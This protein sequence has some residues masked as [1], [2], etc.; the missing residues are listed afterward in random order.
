MAQ[1]KSTSI[2]QSMQRLLLLGLFICTTFIVAVPQSM[3]S[4]AAGETSATSMTPSEN[5]V[6]FNVKDPG[7]IYVTETVLEKVVVHSQ[8]KP[9]ITDALLT[10]LYTIVAL[11]F[12][13]TV[14][15]YW[16]TFNRLFGTQRHPY[17]DV[18]TANWPTVTVV[19][20]AHNEEKVISHTIEALLESDYPANK[21]RIMPINDRST[22]DTEAI[23]KDYA[24]KYP[25]KIRPVFRS[26]GKPGKAA[27]LKDATRFIETEILI[28]FDADYIPGK[29]LLKQ[30]VSPFFDPEVGAMMGRVVPHNVGHNLLTRLMDLERSGGYQVDQQARMNMHLVPQY[31]GT[32][33]GV[34]VSALDSVGGWDAKTLAED[35]DLT[36]RLLLAGWKTV[37]QN[38]SE[39]YEEAPETWDARLKQISRWAKGHNLSTARYTLPLLFNR[40]ASLFEKIDGILL[41][42]VYVMSPLLLLGWITAIIL[43]FLG[44]YLM[45]GVISLL[46]LTSFGALGNFA[47]FFEISAAVR[48]DSCR[49]RIRLLPLNIINFLLSMIA[50]TRA[51][52]AFMLPGQQFRDF[53]E[54][55][56]RFRRKL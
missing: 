55:T 3:A 48:L 40:H 43:F 26:A 7:E 17:I 42:G 44:E 14:R 18:D 9:W 12:I 34:R 21:F 27:A 25:A 49:Q 50:I 8:E 4:Q 51:T 37:Y 10:L 46:V 6:S 32:V 29:G 19:I 39:C 35:T 28:V 54:K 47:A 36:Y 23:I 52:F 41:L 45:F 11:I 22:D 2:M 38:R 56:E 15:H 1:L 24:Q 16:F 20:P 31:G 30:L 13:Y 53:W 33:G 5:S